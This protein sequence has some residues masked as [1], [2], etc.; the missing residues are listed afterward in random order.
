MIFISAIPSSIVPALTTAQMREVDRAMIQDV[1]ISLLQMME[2]AG[3]GLAELARFQLGGR[4]DGETIVILAG[5]GNNG[6]GGMAAARHLANWGA[7]VRVLL[8]GE[9]GPDKSVARQQL[10]TL[11]RIEIPV[12]ALE[13]ADLP[14]ASLYLDALIGYGLTGSPRGR[15][16]AL[17]RRANESGRPIISLDATSGLDTGSGQVFDPCICARATLTLALPKT[18]LYAAGASRVI[19]ELFLAD[20]SVPPQIYARMGIDVP[21]VFSEASVVRLIR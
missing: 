11:K 13:P 21:N 14:H 20:I 9:P 6:G 18:G 10:E 15:A 2:N 1:G 16:A 17:I 19:G 5:P 4:V 3:R 7:H 8:S 12:A